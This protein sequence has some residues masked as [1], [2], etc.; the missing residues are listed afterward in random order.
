MSGK[1]K[2]NFKVSQAPLSYY[3]NTNTHLITGC[4]PVWLLKVKLGLLIC[5]QD[6]ITPSVL[7]SINRYSGCS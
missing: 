7:R 6:I 5:L 1:I 4:S 3:L 2:I